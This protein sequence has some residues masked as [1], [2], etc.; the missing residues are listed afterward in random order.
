MELLQEK[1]NHKM[2]DVV[3]NGGLLKLMCSLVKSCTISQEKLITLRS[4]LKGGHSEFG[5]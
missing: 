1:S 2:C 3:F 5:F 4:L